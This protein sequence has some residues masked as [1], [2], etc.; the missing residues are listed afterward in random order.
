[1]RLVVWRCVDEVVAGE[2]RYTEKM[3]C[4]KIAGKHKENEEGWGEQKD[5]CSFRWIFLLFHF[6]FSFGNAARAPA[7]VLSMQRIEQFTYSWH[8][9]TER[10]DSRKWERERKRTLEWKPSSKNNERHDLI[11]CDMNDGD[12]SSA[13][14][15]SS[16]SPLSGFFVCVCQTMEM[17]REYFYV[18][19][20]FCIL[21]PFACLP[22]SI[23]LQ[24]HFSTNLRW[25]EWSVFSKVALVEYVST[26]TKRIL[27]THTHT[28]ISLRHCHLDILIAFTTPVLICFR[29]KT[30]DSMEFV[31]SRIEVWSINWMIFAASCS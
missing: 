10:T 28:H 11:L 15:F 2:A 9:H 4:R 23:Y 24:T 12:K 13:L 21:P 26:Y 8:T 22:H 3:K 17:E 6:N 29:I 5:L 27:H 25:N 20:D 30:L 1:M 16:L 18:Q 14:F 7:L 31:W 19:H